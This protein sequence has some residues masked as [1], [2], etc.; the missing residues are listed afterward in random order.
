MTTTGIIFR[1][2]P[3]KRITTFAHALAGKSGGY[4]ALRTSVRRELNLPHTP[5]GEQEVTDVIYVRMAKHLAAGSPVLDA[6][7]NLRSQ[8]VAESAALMASAGVTAITVVDFFPSHLGAAACMESI[9]RAAEDGHGGITAEDI[10]RL[11][12][13]ALHF[14][15]DPAEVIE[16]VLADFDGVTVTV[17][18]P[19]VGG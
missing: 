4:L 16:A 17:I 13:K 19:G 15:F 10:R 2:L 9:K 7:T 5:D 3:E 12:R 11:A 18:T 1:H 14:A 8:Y 6:G